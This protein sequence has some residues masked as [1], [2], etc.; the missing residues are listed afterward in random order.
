MNA[1]CGRC[2]RAIEGLAFQFQSPGG[3]LNKCLRCALHHAPM[4]TRSLVIA[5]LV[6]TILVAIN[7]GD[8]LVAGPWPAALAWKVPL[9][10]LVPFLVATSGAL[11]QSRVPRKN[12]PR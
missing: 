9:T 10:Y 12:Q 11:G 2:G 3:L 8:L 4:L 5:A 7:Q 1:V 6:G